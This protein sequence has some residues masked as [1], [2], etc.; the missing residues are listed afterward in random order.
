MGA[1]DLYPSVSADDI[2]LDDEIAKGNPGITPDDL[3]GGHPKNPGEL[4]KKLAN[5]RNQ[6]EQEANAA[7]AASGNIVGEAGPAGPR[8]PVVD[9]FGPDV[10][11]QGGG[12]IA[13]LT[14]D[15][16]KARRASEELKGAQ[17]EAKIEAAGDSSDGATADSDVGHN[18][19]EEGKSGEQLAA[20]SKASAAKGAKAAASKSTAKK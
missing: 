17:Q 5:L 4:R 2:N 14:P 8:G 16:A 10:S 11:P 18:R 6:A 1:D 7:F 13:E 19:S 12:F 20:A 9:R 15:E 3:L